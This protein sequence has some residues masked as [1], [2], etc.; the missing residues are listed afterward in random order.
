M[1]IIGGSKLH[2]ATIS[3]YHDHRIAM[4]FAVAGL[5]AEGETIVEGSE[6]ISTSYPSFERDLNLFIKGDAGAAP[7]QVLSRV[8]RP[9]ADRLRSTNG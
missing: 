5:F 4:A 2:G 6:C 8:S 7:I 3:T 9:V 1:E